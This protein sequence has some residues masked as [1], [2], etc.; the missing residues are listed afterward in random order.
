MCNP[1]H[2]AE[3]VALGELTARGWTC[4]AANYRTKFGEFD[5]LLHTGEA[6]A[7]VEVK[8]RAS[9]THGF[10]AEMLRPQQLQRILRAF[11]HFLF[12]K[13]AL[14]NSPVQVDVFL[15]HGTQAS[16]ATEHIENITG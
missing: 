10:A 2:W 5:L 4:V 1:R 12:S 8:Q 15:V 3:H 13:P 7:L 11:E 6:L 14:A 9:N 16:Y